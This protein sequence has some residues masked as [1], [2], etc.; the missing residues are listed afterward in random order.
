[1]PAACIFASVWSGVSLSMTAIAGTRAGPR[2]AAA[3][4]IAASPVSEAQG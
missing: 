1:M 4:S 3:T 2:S